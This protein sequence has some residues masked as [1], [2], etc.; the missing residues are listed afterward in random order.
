MGTSWHG[1]TLIF[2]ITNAPDEAARVGWSSTDH[3]PSAPSH[4]FREDLP[5]PWSMFCD[6]IVPRR[7]EWRLGAK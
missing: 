7:G 3:L 4:S 1:V 6:A 5:N 2:S